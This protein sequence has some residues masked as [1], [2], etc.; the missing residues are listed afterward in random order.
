MEK[1]TILKFLLLKIILKFY[2]IFKNIYLLNDN[3]KIFHHFHYLIIFY[4]YLYF[5]KVFT[6]SLLM[7]L[8]IIF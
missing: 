3:L 8:T 6:K 4:L 2:N 7:P 1:I 5:F